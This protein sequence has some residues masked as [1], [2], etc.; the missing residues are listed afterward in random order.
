MRNV[1]FLLVVAA[2]LTV[3][4]YLTEFYSERTKLKCKLELHF[5]NARHP[6]NG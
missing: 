3:H 6:M 1:F 5:L 4:V 2:M